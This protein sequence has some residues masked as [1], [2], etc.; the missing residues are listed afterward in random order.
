MDGI[1]GKARELFHGQAQ[2]YRHV[3]FWMPSVCVKSAI[4][5]EIPDIIH[6][7][8]KLIPLSQLVSAPSSTLWSYLCA[9]AHALALS[10]WPLLYH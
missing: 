4:E 3:N 9:R 8:G 5:L 2:L 1:E 6:R 7:H 10:Q